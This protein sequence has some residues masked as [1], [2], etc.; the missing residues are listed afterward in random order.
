MTE[1]GSTLLRKQIAA[2]AQA[3]RGSCQ[4]TIQI[5]PTRLCNLEC[6]HCYTESGPSQREALG[7][8]VL[9]D[10]LTDA[11]SEGFATMSV[12]GGEP[13]LYPDLRA[14]LE[15]AKGVDMRTTV[16]SNGTLLDAA[17][18]RELAGCTDLLAISLD[19][20][21]E[22]HNH[23]RG[24]KDAF[25]MM[26]RHLAAVRASGIPFGFIFTFTQ[27]NAHEVPWVADFAL[28]QGASTLQLHPLAPTGRARLE[29]P[30]SV[31]HAEEA[32]YAY[33]AAMRARQI[34]GSA[35]RIKLNL[36]DREALLEDPGRVFAH[37]PEPVE[38]HRPLAEILS[39][40]VVEAD[41][42]VVPIQYGF[43][44]WFRFGRLG[45]GHR[46]REMIDPWKRE[47]FETFRRMC[48]TVFDI[49]VRG[50]D[51]P[52]IRW[53]DHVTSASLAYDK[54]LQLGT[55]EPTTLAA[56]PLRE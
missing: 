18:L 54:L 28:E 1:P 37:A 13:L 20:V 22:S 3:P 8:T 16:T 47:K 52:V 7:L 25:A 4:R 11:A 39:P 9:C 49:S 51:W 23:I 14:L 19:G 27:F 26:A 15:H 53:S 38:Q 35:V 34:V 5:H 50:N 40:L 46:L 12:S 41:G 31:P 6:R 55:S 36:A 44:R 10:A 43:G 45:H 21:P 32:A 48:T 29:L 30:G 56:S 33:L 17:N 42:T 24:S 2:R